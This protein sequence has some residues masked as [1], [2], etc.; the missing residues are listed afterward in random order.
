VNKSKYASVRDSLEHPQPYYGKPFNPL[1]T[2]FISNEEHPTM[3]IFVSLCFVFVAMGLI[4]KSLL[5]SYYNDNF[6][7]F[8]KI[9]N[10][11]EYRYL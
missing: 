10:K 5:I 4:V 2:P 7:G 8:P 9:Y 3:T 6:F 11:G 1:A